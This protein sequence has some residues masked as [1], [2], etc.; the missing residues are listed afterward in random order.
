MV[1]IIIKITSVILVV[2]FLC[3]CQR[4][5]NNEFVAS[6]NDGSFDINAVQSAT[7][8]PDMHPSTGT[9]SD[10]VGTGITQ[11]IQYT[12]AFLST[13]GTVEFSF[14]IN[15]VVNTVPMPVVEVVPH[16]ITEEDSERVARILLGDANFFEAEPRFAANYSKEEIQAK[17]SRWTAY[18]GDE[19]V[20]DKYI[21]E[22]TVLMETASLECPHTP[23]EWIF[24]NATYY[25]DGTNGTDFDALANDNSEIR[26]SAKVDEI[27]YLFIAST[28]NKTDY[29]LNNIYAYPYDGLS[30]SSIDYRI[31]ESQLCQTKEPNDGVVSSV[32]MQAAEM[33][34]QMGL[35]QWEI[36]QCYVNV[37]TDYGTPEYKIC[38]RA[39]PVFENVAAVRKAQLTNL[40]SE[41]VYASNY[42]LTD[43]Q[44]EFNVNGDLVYFSMDSPVDVKSVINGNV[45]TI[46]FQE[47]IQLAKE[48]FLLSDYYEYDTLL[49]IDSHSEEL[50]CNVEICGFDYGLTRVK[51][52]NT[53]ESYYYVPAI[54][55]KGKIWFYGKESGNIFEISGD[56]D[57]TLPL[58]IL[59]AVDGTVINS[60]NE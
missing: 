36:D 24:K 23:C 1:K 51:V 37:N 27:P 5:P 25:Y 44:F 6:K 13:D 8:P 57:T 21:K 15:E 59:N 42:Y 12:D 10:S 30:P 33:L 43:A 11:V 4:A 18:A 39:V 54:T 9:N 22:Y 53:D 49:L 48:K 41:A 47:L 38:I 58:L 32:K 55:F 52:P 14:K 19:G 60:T 7:E 16:F 34:E 56:Y 2:A 20:V 31:F 29:K 40:K 28:R 17:L 26:A 50:G 3:G 35:G 45:K 46:D